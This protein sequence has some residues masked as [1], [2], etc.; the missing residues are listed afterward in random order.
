MDIIY[1]SVFVGLLFPQP[2]S[3]GV[4]TGYS[5]SELHGYICDLHATAQSHAIPVDNI[6]RR[7]YRRPSNF[8]VSQWD[9]GNTPTLND[10]NYSSEP[11]RE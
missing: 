6:V 7:R 8:E 5:P 11:G 9:L 10:I 1:I 3:F 2:P 4:L